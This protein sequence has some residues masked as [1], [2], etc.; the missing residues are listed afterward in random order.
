MTEYLELA[1]LQNNQLEAD[2]LRPF[3]RLIDASVRR[4]IVLDA[5]RLPDSTLSG[6]C[7]DEQMVQLG[8]DGN[9]VEAMVDRVELKGRFERIHG[10][11]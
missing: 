6:G 5:L 10:K 4:E 1:P 3:F 7:K 2:P 11:L 9:D 8:V